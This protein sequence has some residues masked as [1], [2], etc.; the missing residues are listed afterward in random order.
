[1]ML[2]AASAALATDAGNS[3]STAYSLG[4]IQGTQV[5]KDSVGPS[6]S[7]DYF[8]FVL[9]NQSN[10]NVK[11]SGLSG[12]ANLQILSSAGEIFD[13]S[14]SPGTEAEIISRSLDKGTYYIRVFQASSEIQ[15]P[16]ALQVN[17]DLNYGR[18]RLGDE[19]LNVGF[20]FADGDTRP[21]R[22]DTVTWVVI[23]GYFSGPNDRSISGLANAI[24]GRTRRDQVLKLDWSE[25]AGQS[26]ILDALSWIPAVAKFAASKLK[27][28]GI[29]AGKINLAGHSLGGWVA[30]DLAEDVAGGVNRIIALDPATDLPGLFISGVDYA[31]HSRFSEGFVGSNYGTA[32]ATA[33]ADLAFHLSVGNPDSIVTHSNVVDL[34]ASMIERSYGTNPDPISRLFSIDRM[35]PTVVQPFKLNAYSGGFEGTVTGAFQNSEWVPVKLVYKNRKTGKT[36]V[37]TA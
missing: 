10:F 22:A 32:E 14:A 34:V 28:W 33:T 30:N 13:N 7:D 20:V 24:D 9:K 8:R 2:S 37:V 17:A 23:H 6:D 18:V 3:R 27:S 16:Y 15:T 36:V 12:D 26:S 35:S 29:P 4:A 5:L 19:R 31:E 25:P 21:I 11:L 1:M